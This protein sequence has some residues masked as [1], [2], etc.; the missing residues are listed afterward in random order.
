MKIRGD[1]YDLYRDGNNNLWWIETYDRFK[2]SHVGSSIEYY[3]DTWDDLILQHS[4]FE[5]AVC[6]GDIILNPS[7]ELFEV[8]FLGLENS[9]KVGGRTF[10]SGYSSIV[11]FQPYKLV[12]RHA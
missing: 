9:F 11:K 6:N 10:Y 3:Y 8:I 5:Y 1:R 2:V 4:D 12:Q 7:G